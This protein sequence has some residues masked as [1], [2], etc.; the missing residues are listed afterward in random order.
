MRW[1]T[2]QRRVSD[3]I[4]TPH[5]PRELTEKQY[6]DLEKSLQKFDLVEIPAINT[7]NQLLAGHMR[8]QILLALKR[9]DEVIDVRVPDRELTKAECDEYMVRSNKNTG[10]FS[11]DV[12]ANN[13]GLEDLKDWGFS[14]FDLGLS[15]FTPNTDP[16]IDTDT[17]TQAQIEEKAKELAEQMVKS[18]KTMHVTCPKCGH[19]FTVE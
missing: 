12:L 17:A 11:R 15:G 9:G 2:E 16:L 1:H 6:R 5:N 8:L 3:L 19:D 14:D 10:Q 4:P 7:T 18:S 13:F